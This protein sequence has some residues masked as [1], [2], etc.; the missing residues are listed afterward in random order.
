MRIVILKFGAI[1]DMVFASPLVRALRPHASHLG[2]VTLPWSRP[3]FEHHPLVDRLHLYDPWSTSGLAKMRLAARI[4]GDL[5]REQY[6]AAV[7]LHRSPF[8]PLLALGGG[9]RQRVGFRQ[10]L[11]GLLLTAAVPFDPEM[12]EVR[13]NASLLAGLGLPVPEEPRTE[14]HPEPG[15]RTDPFLQKGSVPLVGLFPGGGV[16]PG[17]AFAWKRWPVAHFVTLAQALKER[18]YRLALFGGPDEEEMCRTVLEAVEGEAFWGLGRS[19][20]EVAAI[21]AQCDLFVGG[22]SGPLHI[23]AAVGTPTLALFGPTDPGLVAPLGSEHRVLRLGLECSPCYRLSPPDGCLHEHRCMRELEPEMVLQA[24]LEMTGGERDESKR[25]DE[26]GRTPRGP[27]GGEGCE[28]LV[29][30]QG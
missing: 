15:V 4:M 18:G 16:N 19:L 29:E 6:D 22:D 3:V 27:L 13:R 23:A 10:R 9:I 14:M 12:H 30:A 21:A 17:M 8:A 24:V 7:I 26:V 25:A 5:R 11:S 1:G 2:I 28:K 20:S